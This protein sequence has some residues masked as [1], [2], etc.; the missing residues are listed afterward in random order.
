[1]Y[2]RSGGRERD[3]SRG[4]PTANVKAASLA[5]GP[6]PI[7]SKEKMFKNAL[8]FN[9]KSA[10]PMGGARDISGLL[11]LGQG[12]RSRSLCTSIACLGREAGYPEGPALREL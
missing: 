3:A 2:V 11:K 7:I 5:R 8:F 9:G 10:Y 1:M 12:T 4:A 6:L